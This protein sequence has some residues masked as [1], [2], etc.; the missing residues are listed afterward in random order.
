[1]K[2]SI[3]RICGCFFLEKE[4][5]LNICE[6]CFEKDRYEYYLVKEFLLNNRGASIMDIFTNTKL[7]LK[8][9]KRFIEDERVEIINDIN[10]KYNY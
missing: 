8:T 4:T 7:P 2:R 3:C 9:I 6:K 1:M 5:S 10:N